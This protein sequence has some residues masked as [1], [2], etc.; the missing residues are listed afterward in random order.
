MT[1]KEAVENHRKMWRWISEKTFERKRK[2]WKYEYFEENNLDS[3]INDCFCC[4]YVSQFATDACV[5]CPIN[6]G[7]GFC[8]DSY[9]SHWLK[10]KY[11]YWF[12]AY[13]ANLIANLPERETKDFDI[14][15]EVV[16]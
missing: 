8:M 5:K 11:S 3:P 12:C 6:W 1:K 13:Y 9:Y 4:E 10:W 16:L 7:N 2:V 14:V 15:E